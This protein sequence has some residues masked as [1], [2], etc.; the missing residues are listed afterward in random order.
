MSFRTSFSKCLG[1]Q[2]VCL[3]FK[4]IHRNVNKKYVKNL[5]T[6]KKIIIICGIRMHY[7]IKKIKT[8]IVVIPRSRFKVVS[9][10]R[11]GGGPA[12]VVKAACLES[13][14]LRVRTPL[15]PP[16]FKETNVSQR[17]NIVGS[18]CDREVA[19]SASD[20]QGNFEVCVEGSV[21]SLSSGGSPGPV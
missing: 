15:W 20:Y 14:R 11:K 5:K 12:A 13:R 6:L 9:C 4:R 3:R 7:V 17:F 2:K 18:L 8:K 21:I 19:C 1:I 10:K 16:S